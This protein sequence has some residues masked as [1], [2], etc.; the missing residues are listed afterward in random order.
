MYSVAVETAH[1][2]YTLVCRVTCVDCYVNC[3][4][5]AVS[6]PRLDINPTPSARLHK[7]MHDQIWAFTSGESPAQ[8]L[9]T[10]ATRMLDSLR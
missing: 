7:F 4:F 3:S 2:I 8:S 1:I 10:F 9:S 6:T 5:S